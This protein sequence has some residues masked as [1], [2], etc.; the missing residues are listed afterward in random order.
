MPRRRRAR[1]AQLAAERE[2]FA[3][4]REALAAENER[5]RAAY[6]QAQLELEL[7][8]R[9]LFVA[10][11]ERVDTRSSSSSSSTWPS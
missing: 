9:R 7:L 5:L 2:A 11:A 1:A 4:E 6:R 10:K 8:R 3:A